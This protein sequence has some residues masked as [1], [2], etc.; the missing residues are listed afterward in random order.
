MLRYWQSE[1]KNCS[2]YDGHIGNS[3]RQCILPLFAECAFTHPDDPSILFREVESQ[4]ICANRHLDH[5]N[6]VHIEK[7]GYECEMVLIHH[8][9]D[10]VWLP[11]WVAQEASGAVEASYD[12]S[13]HA[14]VVYHLLEVSLT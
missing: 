5:S 8:L 12:Y 9:V 6:P 1:V 3:R 7:L 4:E 2:E 10:R 11:E 13:G 14:R